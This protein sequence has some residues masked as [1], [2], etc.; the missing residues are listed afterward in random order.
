[1]MRLLTRALVLSSSL[2]IAIR[3]IP[4]AA[5]EPPPTNPP[6][7][8]EQVPS[9]ALTEVAPP[10]TTTTTSADT[11]VPDALAPVENILPDKPADIAP[12]P[13]API[14][15]KGLPRLHIDADRPGV[16]LLKISRVMSDNEGEGMLVKTI[17]TAPCDQ[18]IDA[19][20]R[21]TIFF[22]AEG[23]VP[24]RGFKLA[25]LEGD[26]VAHVHGGNIVAR[27]LGFLLGAVGGVA[28][29]GGATMLGVGYSQNSAHLSNEGKIVQGPNPTLTTGG[30]I[31][32]GVGTAMV[33][34]AIILVLTAKT[35]ITLVHADDK[36]ARI[37]FDHGVF[38]F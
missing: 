36:S 12:A 28:M 13:T 2:L 18:V 30:L 31:T 33:T 16:R 14:P 20:K 7:G 15:Q 26:I 29:L 35:H 22:G 21:Q 5:A 32:L 17:C 23:M 37:T 25:P 3:S 4:A 9:P 27:Q 34:T 6:T 38:R 24:S 10:T 8:A 19:R 11:A 1:M